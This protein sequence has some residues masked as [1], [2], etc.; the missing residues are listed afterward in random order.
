MVMLYSS[1][2]VQKGGG[3]M[4]ALQAS[5]GG[6]GLLACIVAA[7]IDYRWLR[8]LAWPIFL[9]T[10]VLLGLVL[11][12]GIGIW[13]N[14]SR[15]W[16]NLGIANFQPSELAK[17]SLII[18]LAWYGEKFSKYRGE[19]FKGLI[20]PGGI[21]ALALGLIFVEPDRGTTILLAAITCVMLLLAG[22]KLWYL[23]LPALPLAALLGLSLYN[24]P[25]RLK[26]IIVWLN[27]E[28]YKSDVGYQAWQSMV[29]IGAG[30][31]S[32]LGLGNGRQKLGFVPEHHTDFIF[33]VIGEEL[34]MIAT[35]A[36]V[37]AFLVL[38]LSGIRIAWRSKD[39]FGF[40]LAAG[41]TFLIGFQAFINIGVV[42]NALPNKGL[43]L[44]FISYGGSSLALMLTCIGILLS[45][46][47]HSEAPSREEE[48]EFDAAD[49]P[50][51]R[52][53]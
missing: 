46:A 1:S 7:W 47:R 6:L 17:L 21:A 45:V 5:A 16:F 23:L 3:Q 20:V 50:A 52:T 53:A 44:P 34:G 10:I 28:D 42:T 43:P 22:A 8:K 29:A 41:I 18:I 12:P 30:G 9:I 15:R 36:I 48:D 49:L 40:L 14:G 51:P 26:R 39:T 11:V 24:D 31:V 25:V 38:V 4:L 35:M 27:P 2:M 13:K 37:L 33:S 19:F 32:G